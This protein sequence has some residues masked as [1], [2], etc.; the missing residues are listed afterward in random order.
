MVLVKHREDFVVLRLVRIEELHRG[1]RT[2]PAPSC[3][4]LARRTNLIN[5]S[6]R[7]WYIH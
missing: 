6:C 2:L 5:R 7:K 4:A 1:I 3:P